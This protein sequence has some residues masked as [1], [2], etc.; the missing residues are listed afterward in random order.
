MTT[1]TIKRAA[2]QLKSNVISLEDA[3][4]QMREFGRLFRTSQTARY[5]AAAAY[6][7]FVEQGIADATVDSAKVYVG[8]YLEGVGRPMTPESTK[9][10]VSNFV[11]FAKPYALANRD[12]IRELAEEH[13][14]GGG[15]GKGKDLFA[16]AYAVNSGIN[17]L[18]ADFDKLVKDGKAKE[19]ERAK[20]VPALDAKYVESRIVAKKPA[21]TATPKIEVDPI[22][23]AKAS[24]RDSAQTLITGKVKLSPKLME[25]LGVILR[26]IKE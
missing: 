5:D 20:K 7:R 11:S 21:A 10:V 16:A 8:A 22:V 25:A 1:A 17:K 9:T 19:S 2:R 26:S 14:N 23:A 3:L 12:K 6:S 4:E 13:L 15:T 24:L 18:H